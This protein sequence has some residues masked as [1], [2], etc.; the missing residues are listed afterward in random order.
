MNSVRFATAI[1]S[2][3]WAFWTSSILSF[4]LPIAAV[5]FAWV[6]L[7]DASAASQPLKATDYAVLSATSVELTSY[8]TVAGP[9]YSA[10]N[11]H[12]DFGY[13]IQRPPQNAGDF[14]S[15]ADFVQDSLSQVS[16]DVFANGS[17][18][19]NS[20]NVS[21]NI[22]YGN[23]YTASADSTVGGSVAHQANSV[24]FVGLPPATSFSPG[25]LD[26]IHTTDFALAPGAYGA[27]EE[28]GLFKN[29]HLSSGNYYM[30]S[31]SLNG[32]TSLYLDFNGTQPINVY[33]DGNVFIDSGFNV[34]VNNVAVGNGNNGLQTGLAGLTLFETHGNF[35]IASGFLNYFYG[36][37]FAPSGSVTMDV[38]DM[39]G[40]IL[41]SGPIMGNAYI[42]LRSS[43][44][45]KASGTSLGDYDGSGTVDM[46]DYSYWKSKF[47][48]AHAAADGNGDGIVDAADYS[49]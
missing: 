45:L 10:G 34:F 19:L 21:G 8:S 33:V 29:V 27:V 46:A 18:S 1:H 41:A 28:N 7:A 25:F 4:R 40:S 48:M 44:G 9:V 14:Y 42:S 12:L 32:S 23:Q 20:A 22:K 49:I 24:A 6:L 47:G 38:E 31:L 15:R 5:F 13:G 39:F 37:I 2:S 26:S 11:L 17:V 36:T 16:G 3:I 35:T 43:Q 30:S